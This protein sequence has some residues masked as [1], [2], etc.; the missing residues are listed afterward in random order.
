M[1]PTLPLTAARTRPGLR[2]R[3][4]RYGAGAQPAE[5][6]PI[7][8]GAGAL[9][10]RGYGMYQPQMQHHFQPHYDGGGATAFP[11]PFSPPFPPQPFPQA[12][13]LERGLEHNR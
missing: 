13:A 1:K 5:R 12:R 9:P 2:P 7:G 4:A 10:I 6:P 11:Q 3:P 8:G